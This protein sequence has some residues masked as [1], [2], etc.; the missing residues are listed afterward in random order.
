MPDDQ[1]IAEQLSGL[2]ELFG[3]QMAVAAPHLRPLLAECVV[4]QVR[5]PGCKHGYVRLRFAIDRRAMLAKVLDGRVPASALADM[6]SDEGQI[7]AGGEF[8]VDFGRISCV[9]R[10]GEQIAQWHAEGIGWDEIS[11]RT[12]LKATTASWAMRQWRARH[13]DA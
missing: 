2:T 8:N 9:E 6:A 4:E 10:W 3:E 13:A 7:T 12:G 11:R 1:W 5:R